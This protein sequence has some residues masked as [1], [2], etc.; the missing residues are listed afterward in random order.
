MTNEPEVHGGPRRPTC[1][2]CGNGTFQQERGKIDSMWGIT[3][4][5]VTLLI[6]ERCGNIL[7]FYEGNTI[8]D[9]D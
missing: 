4:H 5:R 9:F 8:F 1:P 7:S 3:A 6:C 2:L